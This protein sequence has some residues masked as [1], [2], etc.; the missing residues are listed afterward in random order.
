MPE[1]ATNMLDF[2]GYMGI[3]QY[4]YCFITKMYNF[5]VYRDF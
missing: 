3:I 4:S 1:C 2:K 5:G